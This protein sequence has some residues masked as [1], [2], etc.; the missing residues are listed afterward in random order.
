M[1]DQLSVLFLHSSPYICC[2][3]LSETGYWISMGILIVLDFM[4]QQIQ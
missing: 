3:L 4:F 2:L 1:K